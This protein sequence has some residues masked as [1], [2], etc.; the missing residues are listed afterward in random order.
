MK[1]KCDSKKLL[2]KLADMNPAGST[3]LMNHFI[4]ATDVCENWKNTDYNIIGQPGQ[5]LNVT[6]YE[7]ILIESFAGLITRVFENG[8]DLE[9]PNQIVCSEGLRNTEMLHICYQN[10]RTT[11]YIKTPGEDPQEFENLDFAKF[12]NLVS[13]IESCLIELQR[14]H[15]VKT[16][17][18]DCLS[19]YAG[20]N[21]PF[22]MQQ[23]LERLAH[24]HGIIIIA[25]WQMF[26]EV[27]GICKIIDHLSTHDSNLAFLTKDEDNVTFTYGTPQKRC[28]YRL[29]NG[30]LIQPSYE[31]KGQ[32]LLKQ[33]LP[34]LLK[35]P[36]ER[37]FLEVAMYG[38]L[39]GA[40]ADKSCKNFVQ[41]GLKDGFI[42]EDKGKLMFAE[43]P[44]PATQRRGA[45]SMK[46]NKYFPQNGYKTVNRRV[47]FIHFGDLKIVT[48]RYA[49]VDKKI[50]NAFM[51]YLMVAVLQGKSLQEIHCESEER[52]ILIVNICHNDGAE[53]LKYG[54]NQFCK[55]N[56][57]TPNIKFL[58]AAPETKCVDFYDLLN[59]EN[60]KGNFLFI[61]GLENIDFG[62]FTIDDVILELKQI[63]KRNNAAII[64]SYIPDI[65]QDIDFTDHIQTICEIDSIGSIGDKTIYSA[66]AKT[67]NW[68]TEICFQSSDYQNGLSF[69][70]SNTRYKAWLKSAIGHY[71]DRWTPY[72][73][74]K[75]CWEHP[76]STSQLKKGLD[77]GI[78][79]LDKK[80]KMFIYLGE[81]DNN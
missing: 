52:N 66:A 15:S 50:I 32:L 47:P 76:I 10:P 74:L 49:T 62:N 77:L 48:D 33:I 43:N 71:K 51:Q 36:M 24:E 60:A 40:F 75:T 42:V 3:A 59:S 79:N 67:K 53:N 69:T 28:I 19:I 64:S 11:F 17:F 22:M 20:D 81:Y 58:Q 61:L 30:K 16:V 8:W 38:Y 70:N 18:I 73:E 31:L 1:F 37:K 55:K 39:K 41:R 44:A 25:G 56:K 72:D 23:S 57:L 7:D 26:N 2:A 63:A 27:P 65:E 35:Q 46:T 68:N 34:I 45:I 12:D 80:K 29:D 4:G 14:V 9:H 13:N 6:Y 78:V 54:I 21:E 5:V